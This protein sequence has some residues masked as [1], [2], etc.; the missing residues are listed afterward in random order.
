MADAG[1]L[2]M[3]ENIRSDFV[4][5]FQLDTVWL[6]GF[7]YLHKKDSGKICASLFTFLAKEKDFKDDD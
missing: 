4:I 2:R 7:T 5:H 3:T 1:I 6:L